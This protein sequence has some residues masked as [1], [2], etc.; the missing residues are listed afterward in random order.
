MQHNSFAKL[1]ISGRSRLT[2]QKHLQYHV[3][4]EYHICALYTVQ[5]RGLGI[6]K[7]RMTNKTK[8]EVRVSLISQC[9]FEERKKKHLSVYFVRI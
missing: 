1:A 6:T 4:H 9:K 8:T 7:F 3:A 5:F 2:T